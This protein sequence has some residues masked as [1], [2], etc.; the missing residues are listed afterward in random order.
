MGLSD[1]GVQ[2]HRDEQQRFA[3]QARCRR[4]HA[5]NKGRIGLGDE[6]IWRTSQQYQRAE[7]ETEPE[8]TQQAP[9]S[10]PPSQQRSNAPNSHAKSRR[11]HTRIAFSRH[12]LVASAD[13]LDIEAAGRQVCS[14]ILGQ[15]SPSPTLRIIEL[16]DENKPRAR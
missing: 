6:K 3:P 15:L 9:A 5:Y 13:H 2:I 7:R 10:N 8:L 4:N 14:E 1:F 16:F 11:I 12:V